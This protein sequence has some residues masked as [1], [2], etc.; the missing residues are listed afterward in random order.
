MTNENLDY[1]NI[2]KTFYEKNETFVNFTFEVIKISRFRCRRCRKIFSFNNSFYRHFRDEYSIQNYSIDVSNTSFSFFVN[3][4]LFFIDVIKK[5]STI[6]IAVFDNLFSTFNTIVIAVSNDTFNVIIIH[7]DVDVFVDV[8]IDYDFRD[9]NYVKNKTFLSFTTSTKNVCF[10]FEIDVFLIDREFYKSQTFDIFVRIIIISLK[11]RDFETKMHETSEYVITNIHLFDTK[12]DKKITSIIRR[13]IHLIDDLKINMLFENDIMKSEK[14]VIDIAKKFVVVNSIDVTIFLKTRFVK[15]VIQKSMHLRKIVVVFSRF[16]MKIV[17]HNACL[18]KN[19][20]FLFEFDDDIVELIMY[21]HIVDVFMF[22]IL[23]RND[24]NFL[25]KIFKNYRFDKIIE[26]DFF[27]V[28]QIQTNENVR[29]LIVRQFKFTHR[30]DWFKKM[31]F[32]CVVVYVV[33]FVIFENFLLQKFF[34]SISIISTTMIENFVITIDVESFLLQKL[35]LTTIDVESS[36]LQK[37]F[38]SKKSFANNETKNFFAITKIS[39]STKIIFFND[40]IIHNFE[41]ADFFVKIVEKFSILWND[42]EFVKLSKKNWIRI[43]LKSDWKN[44]IIDKAK[45]Y[46]LDVKNRQL[47]DDIFDEFH[48]FE[49][50]VWTNE[51]TSFFY[52]IFCIWKNVINENDEMKKKNRIIIDIRDFNFITKSNAYSLSLQTNIFILVRK[53]KFISIIDCVSFFYQ[54]RVHSNDKHKLIVVNHRE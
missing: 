1:Y 49:K 53:C 36:L 24:K 9:W 15:N 18:S 34:V 20:N 21:V 39:S 4:S 45:I 41:I 40:V 25:I 22:S 16:E 52:S 26:I 17:V 38:D 6:D 29:F 19:K 8:D 12:N 43:F 54:W 32:A 42:T 37:F 31:I 28:F 2:E 23:I 5:S 33:V 30:D 47:I 44:K 10:D 7:F 46:S 11:I 3:Q 35:F 13:E 27:N 14:I 48:R 50:F 51:S